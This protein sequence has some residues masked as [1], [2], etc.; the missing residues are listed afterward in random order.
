MKA[1]VI[2]AEFTRKE[3]QEIG[4][5]LMSRSNMLDEA[6]NYGETAESKECK[7]IRDLVDKI[8]GILRQ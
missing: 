4:I 2:T 7:E 6:S 3:L 1:Q 5:A 8:Q